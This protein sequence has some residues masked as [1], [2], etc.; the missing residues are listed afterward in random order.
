MY[1]IKLKQFSGPLDKLLELIEEKH[2]DITEISLAEVTADFLK[3]AEQLG[4]ENIAPMIL[5]DFLAVAARLLLIKSKTLLPTLEL[6]EEEKTDIKDLE[7]R[8]KL[9]KEFKLASVIVGDLW[10]KKT[11]MFSRPLFLS[12]GEKSFFYPPPGL[13]VQNLRG[14]LARLLSVLKDFLP[15][16]QKIKSV[17]VKLEDKI[18]E[19]LERFQKTAEQSFKT[20]IASRSKQEIIVLFL[21][22]LHLLKERFI[23]VE[24]KEQF[25]DI[26]LKKWKI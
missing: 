4:K 25:S 5:A 10:N 17:V 6:T 18:Q 21:A 14:C 19:L 9:Y 16:T 11:P 23:N 3:Y 12:L 20:L 24:Q 26:I 13:K 1:Q 15:E 8:L 7:E 22:A 2:L